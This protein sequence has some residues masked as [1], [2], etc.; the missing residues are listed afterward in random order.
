MGFASLEKVLISSTYYF[1]SFTVLYS[2]AVAWLAFRKDFQPQRRFFNTIW[3]P[4]VAA[5]LIN[6]A[7]FAAVRPAF[8]VLEDETQLMNTSRSFFEERAFQ[9]PLQAV[10]G[11]LAMKFVSA[12]VPIRPPLFPYLVSLVHSLLGYS[13]EHAF[14]LNFIVSYGLLF[15][16]IV[17]G[18]FVKDTAFGVT[19]ACLL[20]SFPVYALTVAS[21]GFDSLNALIVLLII[22]QSNRF[23]STARAV[24][25]EMVVLLCA[26]GSLCRYETIALVAP[27]SVGLGLL[28]PPRAFAGLP[29]RIWLT[30]LFFVPVI[31]HRIAVRLDARSTGE[32]RD[33]FR[34][35]Y[36]WPNARHALGFFFNPGEPHYPN[37]VIFSAL[38]VVGMGLLF[39]RRRELPDAVKKA[40]LVAAGVLA[41]LA[42][43][44]LFFVQGDLSQAWTQRFALVFLVPLSLVAAVPVYPGL[45]RPVL[46]KVLPALLMANLLFHLGVARKNEFALK[47][48]SM[49][50]FYERNIRLLR[51]FAPK[52]TLLIA[53]APEIYLVYLYGAVDF[54]EANRRREELLAKRARGEIARILVIQALRPD[55]GQPREFLDPQFRLKFV[56]GY[57]LD[58]DH[59]I[60][61][62]QVL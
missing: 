12:R 7:I 52:D 46:G 45:S 42:S 38:A 60:R 8:R 39:A 2:L 17:Y 19:A 33:L 50:S 23:I 32:A 25:L 21:A 6:G 30:P 57:R 26:L 53:D 27:V 51:P 16:V 56:D 31:V 43:L 22:V 36:A 61:I 40:I 11:G 37:S 58:S 47:N 49:A 10:S 62:S 35:A 1:V 9:T 14:A 13:P 48:Y 20:A 41:T 5:A 24:D 4:A 3:F 54:G 34:A 28:S 59:Y 15:A 29:K 44:Y 18:R 55:S